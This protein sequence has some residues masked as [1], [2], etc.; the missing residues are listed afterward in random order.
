MRL[1]ERGK[2]EFVL[3]KLLLRRASRG[4]NTPPVSEETIWNMAIHFPLMAGIAMF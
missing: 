2:I 4:R 3:P 1:K